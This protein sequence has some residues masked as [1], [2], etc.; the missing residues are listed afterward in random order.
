M[1]QI[2]LF[3]LSVVELTKTDLT[4]LVWLLH[5]EVKAVIGIRAVFAQWVL[6]P[7]MKMV[8]HNRGKGSHHF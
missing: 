2:I 7:G 6:L 8:N 4:R 3:L 1:Y 5:P